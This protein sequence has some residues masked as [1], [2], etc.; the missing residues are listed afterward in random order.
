[1]AIL[2]PS[3]TFRDIHLNAEGHA[4]QRVIIAVQLFSRSVSACF[5]LEKRPDLAYFTRTVNDWFDTLDSRSPYCS[6]NRLKSG[7]GL[8]YQQQSEALYKMLELMESMVVGTEE[9]SLASPITAQSLVQSP[10]PSCI[11]PGSEDSIDMPGQT[12]PWAAEINDIEERYEKWRGVDNG[13]DSE[14]GLTSEDEEVVFNTKHTIDKLDYDDHDHFI[15][16][17]DYKLKMDKDDVEMID[18][19]EGKPAG[20]AMDV[21]DEITDEP[22]D[23]IKNESKIEPEPEKLGAKSE[24]RMEVNFAMISSGTPALSVAQLRARL[25]LSRLVPGLEGSA[26]LPWPEQTL[27]VVNEEDKSSEHG[28]TSEDEE[29]VFNVPDIVRR[30]L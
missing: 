11:A 24:E 12:N 7:F 13:D 28:L 29:M 16:D 17:N 20:A 6:N 22:D 8:F 14:H 21:E 18:G 10:G 23:A 30:C 9:L 15:T 27:E 1:M 19:N 2:M 26:V 25:L 3:F 4:A 5:E